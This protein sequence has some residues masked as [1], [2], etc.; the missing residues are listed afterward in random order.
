MNSPVV[1]DVL[2]RVMYRG[3]PLPGWSGG[4]GDFGIQDKDNRLHPGVAGDGGG[5]VFD[6]SL[7]VKP[8]DRPVF[9]GPLAHG[10]PKA[11]FLYLSWRNTAG[12]YARRLKLP[13]GAIT[14]DDVAAA[15]AAPL[16]ADLDDQPKLT[17][18]GVYIGGSRAVVW[19]LRSG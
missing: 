2:L 19:T 17:S 4:P 14:W 1:G 11:R 6:L 12:G 7:E 5:L 18:T 3:A 8:G 10:P 9:A 16:V 15:R 13:L